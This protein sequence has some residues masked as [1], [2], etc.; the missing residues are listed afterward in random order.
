MEIYYHKTFPDDPWLT[1]SANK[2][3]RSYLKKT[4]IGLEL[5]SGRSTIWFAKRTKHLTSVEHNEVWYRKVSQAI[6]KSELQNIDY[7]LIHS[8]LSD[9]K[10]ENTA[11]VRLINRFNDNIFDY[12]LIDGIYR[13]FCTLN[14]L[15]KIRPGG[16]LIIDNVNWFLPSE[17]CSPC[18]R[19]YKL[20]AKGEIWDRIN[21]TISDWRTIWTSSGVTDT[22]LFIKP[23]N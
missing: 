7:H 16:V 21:I 6:K 17:S 1:K 15:G 14:V 4:D 9:E 10:G 2:I 18:S 8:D 20:G 5:G 23:C 22:A 3:L 12:V 13:D 19:T 11:Y